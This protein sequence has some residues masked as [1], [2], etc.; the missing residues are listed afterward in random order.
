M[1]ILLWTVLLAA[2]IL[3]G[4]GVALYFKGLYTQEAI[5]EE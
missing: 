5:N 3:L 4:T 2:L 1:Q